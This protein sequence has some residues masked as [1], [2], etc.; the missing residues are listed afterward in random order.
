MSQIIRPTVA[1]PSRDGIR[2]KV[3][4]SGMATMSDS[5]IALKPV[6]DE[7]SKP[8][9]SSSAPSISDGVIAKLF[10]CPSMS[11]NQKRTYSTPSFS[12]ASSTFLRA[13]GSD[14]ARSLLSIIPI[15][16]SLL[17]GSER[18][19]SQKRTGQV[20]PLEPVHVA[21]LVVD[22]PHRRVA[23]VVLR[24]EPREVGLLRRGDLRLLERERDAATAGGARDTRHRVLG[25][26]VLVLVQEGIP[27][28]APALQRD[29][30]E[31]AEQERPEA[32]RAPLL[33]RAALV[34]LSGRDV[35]VGLERHLVRAAVEVWGERADLDPVRDE[36]L[37]VRGR[38]VE[39]HVLHPAGFLVAAVS[40]VPEGVCVV[41]AHD[42]VEA[43]RAE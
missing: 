39:E 2:R 22:A 40:E 7:P 43:L 4:G 19:S 1:R 13:F 25:G 31:V 15:C 37:D 11:V 18:S 16:V 26:V 30:R 38:E 5:S 14:V 21:E 24:A 12:T 29:E 35:S 33:E 27:D 23:E 32:V 36:R 3:D 8:M 28:D 42:A 34:L 9:P 20:H 10:R 6:I 17:P 41:G